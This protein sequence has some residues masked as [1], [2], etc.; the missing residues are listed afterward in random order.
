MG[1]EGLTQLEL[2][3]GTL[4]LI[5]LIVAVAS[6]I[7]IAS[8]YFKYKQIELLTVGLVLIFIT[9]G[10]WGATTAFVLYL[11]F[12]IEISD[13]LYIFIS[14]AFLSASLLF[15]LY[16]FC[17]LVYPNS[18]WIIVS[19][20]LAISIIYEIFFI[21]FL[22]KDPSILVIRITRF[23]S[24]TQPF[25]SLYVVFELLITI[26]TNI[27]FFSKSSKSDD[28]RIRWKGRFI[29]LA[30]ILFV[31]GAV[32]DSIIVLSETMLFIT[33]SLLM[34]SAVINYIGWIMPDRVARWLIKER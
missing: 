16:S 18:K 21:Y 26:I 33:R 13:F 1:I 22:F 7:K 2:I 8:S 32:L 11:F 3:H 20:F 10:W 6:G 17:H 5:S 31:T 30:L 34:L 4:G 23:D 27:I 12:D 14:Y 15:W 9:S 25:V 29:F 19:I 24:E 28:A